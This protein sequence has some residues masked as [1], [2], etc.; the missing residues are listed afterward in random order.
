MLTVCL[1]GLQDMFCKMCL[2]AD[3]KSRVNVKDGHAF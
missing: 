2:Q 3:I 1:A